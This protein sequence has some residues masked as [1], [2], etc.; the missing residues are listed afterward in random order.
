MSFYF[1]TS[2]EQRSLALES[3]KCLAWPAHKRYIERL[4][5]ATGLLLTE[6]DHQNLI[7]SGRFKN[8]N[9]TTKTNQTNQTKPSRLHTQA[10]GNSQRLR[11]AGTYCKLQDW[12]GC[13]LRR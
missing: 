12:V 2:L 5:Q 9:K 13:R 10:L 7:F 8:N 11:A 1:T 6:G 4:C 3:W